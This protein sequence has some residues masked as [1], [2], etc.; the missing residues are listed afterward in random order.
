MKE[1][2]FKYRSRF[3]LPAA[4][5]DYVCAL[6]RLLH[7]DPDEA[8]RAIIRMWA[9]LDKDLSREIWRQAGAD[10]RGPWSPPR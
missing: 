5:A 2:D 9:D 3:S 8:L 7:A 4:E 6:A 1:F 10:G